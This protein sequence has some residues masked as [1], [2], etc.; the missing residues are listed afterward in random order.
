[1]IKRY[2]KIELTLLLVMCSLF[3]NA[4][5]V[6]IEIS[7]RGPA[8]GGQ[9]FVT[10][11]AYEKLTGKAYGEVDPYLPQN[12]LITD[13]QLAPRNAR[14]M[15]EYSTDIYILKPLDLSKGNHKLFAELP[16]RGGK[17]LG[18]FN[19]SKGGNDPGGMP[20]PDDAFLMSRGYTIVWCGWD[21]SATAG[22]NNMTITVPIAMD[23]GK[24][25]TGLS[26]EYISFDNDK[27]LTYKLAYPTA[28][29]DKS[30]VVLTERALLNDQSQTKASTDW[31]F[32][33]DHTIRLL[34]AGTAFKQSYIYEFTY[35]AKD[36][37]IAGLGLAATRDVIS[38]LHYSNTA[39]NPMAGDVQYT[40]S[41]AVSQPARYMNDFQT[42]GF[43]VDEVGRRVFDGVENWLGGGSGV[44]INYRFAQPGRTE[45]NR[46]NHLYPEGVFPFAYPVL[47]DKVSGKTMGRLSGY[48]NPKIQPKVMEVNSANEY[49]VKAA[50]LLHTDLDGKD[51]SDPENVRFYLISGMQH[52]TG[53]GNNKG[54]G[55]QLQNPSKAEPV[56]RALFI[57]LDDW[58][59]KNRRPPDSRVPRRDNQ[60]AAFAR[61]NKGSLTGTVP[62]IELGW[63]TIPGVTYTGLVTTRYYFDY[64]PMFSKGIITQYPLGPIDR[65]AYVNLVSKVDKDGNE[66][67]GIRLPSVAIPTGTLTGWGLRSEAYGLNDGA[68]SAGQYI[69]FRKTADER[70]KAGDPRLSLEERY[71]THAGYV[72]AVEAAVGGL[73]Y[74]RFLLPEDAQ[75]YID[76]AEKNDML[77]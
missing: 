52:G 31:E 10:V 76:E 75:A 13:I 33:D 39:A 71:H 19:K 54:S 20:Q 24:S 70:L 17:L 59:T 53:N 40:Y 29:L 66:I 41:F 56:L 69:P 35:T 16:N 63:P 1:M 45:R 43:N 4:G 67:A 11:G 37:K 51:L 2:Y 48:A 50:S 32:A 72:K 74:F 65:P 62:Q 5:I 47:T 15:V 60:S 30:K 9:I 38:F 6:R 73:Q 61:I 34:P 57:D 77:K 27:T 7:S 3:S 42:L 64:G 58:V 44:G 22:N 8:F 68:E 46:Q 49:W 21:I 55:Q 14:G 12:A 36:A 26:Y 18:G 23:K 28:S 25:V